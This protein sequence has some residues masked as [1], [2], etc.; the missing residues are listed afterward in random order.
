MATELTT[1]AQIKADSRLQLPQ[2]VLQIEGVDT[3][4]GIGEI[5]K[6]IRIGDPDLDIGDEW[7]IGGLNGYEDQLDVINLD[8]SS[9]TISQ[10]LLQDK[11]GTSSVP[12]IQISLI[13]KNSLITKLIT[14]GEIIE[15]ILGRKANVYL[16]YQDTAWPQDFVRIFSGIVD[17][18]DSGPTIILNVAHPEQKKRT[19]L[20]QK[21]STELTT[22][23]NFRS[24]KIQKIT[25]QT[26]RDVVGIVTVTYTSGATVGNEIVNVA[27]TNIVIQID[28]GNTQAR[29]IRNKIEASIDAL[30]LVSIKVES[31]F[32][33]EPQTIQSL[34]NLDSDTTIN[35]ISTQGLLLPSPANG[36]RTYVR[37]DDEVIEYTGL[38]DTTLTGCT[39]GA[40]SALDERAE[41]TFHEIE[42]TVD[43][44]YRLQG[45]AIDLTLKLLMS[46]GLEFFASNVQIKSIVEVE[47]VGPI[48][49]AVWFENLNIQDAYGVVIGDKVSITNDQVIAN[50]V[51]DAEVQ[52]VIA[53]PFGSYLIL[54]GVT[55]VSNISSEGLIAFKS[56]YNLLPEGLGLGGD[57]VDVPEFERIKE[58]FASSIFTYDYFLKDSVEG[59]EFIDT[60]LL[61]PTGAFS[62]PRRGKTSVG[63]TSPPLGA[64]SIKVLDSSNTTKP[65]QN[66]IRRS[67]NKYFYN[68]VLFK[69]NESVIDDKFLSGDLDVN[70][71]S[72]NRIKVGNK[73]LVI[74][75]PGLRPSA[76]TNIIIEILKR[77]FQDKY[78][79]AAE[80]VQMSAFY[81]KV[82]DTDIGDVVVFGDSNLQLPDT[83][84]GS[85]NFAP[86]LFEVVNKS[87]SIKT[88]EVKL[89]LLD[90]AYSLANGRYGI[91]SPA[92]LTVN[93]GSSIT[94][95]KIKNSFETVSPR[96]ERTKWTPYIGQKLVVH[97]EDWDFVATT[98][99]VGFAPSDDFLMLVD[100]PLPF[101]VG[102]NY[103]VDIVQYPN[104]AD[105]EDALLLKRVFVYTNP[106]VG[107]LSGISQTVF[108]V[109]GLDASKFL[110]GAI[111]LVRGTGDESWDIVSPEVKVI[112]VTGSQVT[113][114][115]PLGF[116]PASGYEID[117]IGFK[118]SGAPYRYL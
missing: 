2:L 87:L 71:D 11:G 83:R 98:T 64:G 48:P 59:K 113:V 102:D 88:G 14:P 85:R 49:N 46:N 33:N 32:S 56:K 86:R 115:T 112:D 100:P 43:S 67:I 18:I 36:L 66:K 75:V 108:T 69:Y 47:G 20:F 15:D 80:S 61:Y 91:V 22:D 55:L 52:D 21:I 58:T 82:F 38:T 117:L 16:G 12:S 39:R 41:G 19:E 40:L 74:E 4:Y 95:I 106:T 34:T 110:E 92:S 105:P 77:R 104:N 111:L 44:F 114:D 60:K 54:T 99:L 93:A 3:I 42:Q 29:H 30:S 90:S 62:L 50:N 8:A 65:N 96:R 37:I 57:E 1:A 24:A 73:T 78:K 45:N 17:A 109:S 94:Q 72:K 76:D 35:V 103:V 26:R 53:T 9:N 6:F 23:L 5:K 101:I 81:G 116:V 31:N 68:N 89:E 107:I 97:D 7:Q 25:Y 63:Y 28:P 51:V 70:Q 118:D 27:G 84:N 13:D 10:Q 79:F